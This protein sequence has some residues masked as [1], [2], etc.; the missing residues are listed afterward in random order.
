MPTDSDFAFEE[1]FSGMTAG[2]V[3]VI[4]VV[5]SF[6]I[7]ECHGTENES[8]RLRALEAAAQTAE[9][10]ADAGGA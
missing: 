1:W 8:A 2:V 9:V 6:L 7:G 5:A 3:L 10:T 4:V